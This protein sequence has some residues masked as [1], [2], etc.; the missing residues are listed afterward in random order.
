MSAFQLEQM[1]LEVKDLG[2]PSKTD[3]ST[4]HGSKATRPN[5]PNFRKTMYVKLNELL[6]LT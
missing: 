1:E 5:S 2:F 6:R 3:K 4:T